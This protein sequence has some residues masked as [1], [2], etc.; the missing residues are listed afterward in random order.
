VLVVSGNLKGWPLGCQAL[1][2]LGILVFAVVVTLHQM[3]ESGRVSN[4]PLHNAAAKGKASKVMDILTNNPASINE[5]DLQGNTALCLA[6]QN[7]HADIAKIL[8]EAGADA[9]KEG[10]GG[11]LPLHEAA[12][13]GS[14]DVARILIE[15]GASVN[16]KTNQAEL[17]IHLAIKKGNAELVRL[18]L[19]GGSDMSGTL[20][21]AVPQGDEEMVRFLLDRGADV[22]EKEPHWQ[23]SPLHSAARH[24]QA[25]VVKVL[26]TAGA[27]IHAAN[28]Q[29]E[30]PIDVARY[31]VETQELLRK[32][33]ESN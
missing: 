25:S 18:L 28:K 13:H 11:W 33:E 7:G 17:P 15:N 9:E 19:D 29:Q 6:A 22:N 3:W 8:L 1:I 14:I 5:W 20:H 26:L 27:D 4:L 32:H 16:S 30:K 21:A 31:S 24:G 2:G 12:Y 10:G 23:D